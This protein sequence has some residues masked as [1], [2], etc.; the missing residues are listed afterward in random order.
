MDIRGPLGMGGAPL[1]NLFARIEES[2]A[3]ATVQAA[4]DSGIRHF[5]TAPHYGA[6][7]SEHRMGA[8]LRRHNRGGFT[9]STKVGRLLTAAP[10]PPEGRQEFIDELPFTRRFD[11]SADAAMRSIE[12]SLQRL[13]LARIDLVYIH[14][15][16]EDWHGPD[17]KLRFAEAMAGAAPV[18]SA[19]KRE[20]VIGGW[21]LGVNLVEPCL[22]A[23]EQSAPDF[24]LLAGRYTLLDHTALDG[25]MPACA[26]RGVR[27]VLGGPYNSGLLAGGTTFNYETAA[28]EMA[29]RARAI[30]EVCARH[31][32]DLKAAALQFCAAHP[33]VAA[34]IPGARTPDEVRQNAAMMT[35]PIPLGLWQALKQQGLLPL[36]APTPEQ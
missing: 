33:V 28:P 26:A 3:D 23:L 36:H 12:D 7:L 9:L 29:A 22:A 19:L 30:G 10:N 15:V 13:G 31:G 8:A 5:D 14:D 18:L 21:G 6:G 1:G 11:Y 4:W 34:V 20:G 2:V 27:L 35:A 16:S 24:F 25:L 32:V 17:W